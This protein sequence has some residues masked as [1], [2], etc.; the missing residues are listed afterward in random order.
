MFLE[1]IAVI[2]AGFAGAGLMLALNWLSG[3]RLPGWI[4]PVGAGLAM[5]GTTIASEYSWYSRTA[6]ALPEG[7]TVADTR[8]SRA[9]W[10]PWTYL[11]PMTEGFIAVDTANLQPNAHERGHYLA[12]VSFHGRWRPVTEVHFMVDCPGARRADPGGG[13]GADPVW[14]DA[15]ADDPIVKTVCEAV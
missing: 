13:D 14:R 6:G 2:F 7:I 5:L 4:M 12:R 3:R 1:L 15:G 10:R 9:A 8:A 11:V